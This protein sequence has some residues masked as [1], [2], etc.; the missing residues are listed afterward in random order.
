MIIL[1][2]DSANLIGITA[3]F[4]LKQMVPSNRDADWLIT[5]VSRFTKAKASERL[6]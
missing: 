4:Q 2:L 1:H 6:S 5:N 3:H